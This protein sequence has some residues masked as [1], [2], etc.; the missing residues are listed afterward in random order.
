V[1][2]GPFGAYCHR[3]FRTVFSVDEHGAGCSVGRAHREQ[4]ERE[5][6][7]NVAAVIRRLGEALLNKTHGFH[8]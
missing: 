7:N 2:Y 1:N 8:S 3:C 6:M 5:R 4:E